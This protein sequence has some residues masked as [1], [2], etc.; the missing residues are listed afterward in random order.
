MCLNPY[1]TGSYSMRSIAQIGTKTGSKVL[2]LIILEVTLWA[3]RNQ[4]ALEGKHGLNPYYT[5]SYSM[6]IEF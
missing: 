6:R 1:Y 4:R 2:I 5:G 3:N